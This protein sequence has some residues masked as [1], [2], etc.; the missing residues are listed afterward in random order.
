MPPTRFRNCSDACK[1]RRWVKA[2]GTAYSKAWR[3]SHRERAREISLLHQNR[4]RAWCEGSD[5]S[6]TSQEWY[7]LCLSYAYA[8]AYCEAWSPLTIDHRIPLSRGGSNSIDNILPAC[9]SCNLK[10]GTKTE[11]EFRALLA[12]SRAAA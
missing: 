9:L 2:R 3:A 10:K 1:K 11:S 7:R 12:R 5:G 8:C 4:R 6:F